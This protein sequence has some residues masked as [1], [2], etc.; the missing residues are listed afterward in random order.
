MKQTV[1]TFVAV[2]IDAAPRRAAAKLIAKLAAAP[3]DANWVQ[4]QNL[5]LTLKFL[6]D[7]PLK[8]IAR[9]CQTVQKAAEEVPP[10]ELSI[11]GTGAFPTSSRPRTVWI[12]SLSGQESMAALH[13]HLEAR[14]A[15]L[16]FRKDSRRFQ[17]HLTIARVRRGGPGLPELARL[18]EENAQCEIGKTIVREAVVYSSE[19]SRQGPTYHPLGRAKLIG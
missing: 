12:G 19:L 6:G 4:P 11:G 16:G 7:V 5:H 9:I 15:K 14:L 8:E 18:I 1:R 10:F 2:D 13:K 17:A 3:V